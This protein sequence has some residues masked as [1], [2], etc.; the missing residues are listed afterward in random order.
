MTVNEL[1]LCFV[2]WFDRVRYWDED[3]ENV[4]D[5]ILYDA[6]T[7]TLYKERRNEFLDKYGDYIVTDWAYF[8]AGNWIDLTIRKETT[9]EGN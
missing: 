8:W 3:A 6:D 5:I 4:E 1:F 7:E 2:Y 9:D